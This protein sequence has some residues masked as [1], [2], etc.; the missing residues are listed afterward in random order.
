MRLAAVVIALTVLLLI[1]VHI[2]QATHRVFY[3]VRGAYTSQTRLVQEIS[4][5]QLQ[6]ES[7]LSPQVL[8]QNIRE[9]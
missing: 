6:L 5:K 3:R 1:T 4:R 2:R 7:Y 9:Q 8:K